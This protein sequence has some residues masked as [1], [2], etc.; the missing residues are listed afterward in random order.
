MLTDT[1]ESFWS[2]SIQQKERE[3]YIFRKVIKRKK[4]EINESMYTHEHASQ[5][6]FYV[7]LFF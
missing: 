6:G 3:K 4:E 1:C 2:N 5:Y 7:V